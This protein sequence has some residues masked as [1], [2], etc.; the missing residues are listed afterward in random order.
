MNW[1]VSLRVETG[2]EFGGVQAELFFDSFGE[3]PTGTDVCSAPC[4]CPEPQPGRDLGDVGQ[5]DA[6]V[7]TEHFAGGL[8]AFLD[9]HVRFEHF[10]AVPAEA[11]GRSHSM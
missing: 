3:P 6:G 11:V 7:A 10:E 9:G 2:P 4:W 5:G 1:S 8:G